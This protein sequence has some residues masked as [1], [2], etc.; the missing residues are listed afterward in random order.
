MNTALKLTLGLVGLGLVAGVAGSLRAQEK[1][2]PRV[3]ALASGHGGYLG[4]YISDVDREVVERL[5]LGEEHGV[6]IQDVAEEGPA[7][8]AGLQEDDVIVSLNGER[9]ESAAQLRRILN[10]T[11][12]G[13]D[14]SL[15]LIR[16]GSQRTISLELGERRSL[17]RVYDF[18]SDRGEHFGE[19]LRER[20][21]R[22]RDNMQDMRIRMRGAPDVHTF[23]AFGG[24]GRLGVSIQSLGDQLGEYFGLGD[25]T[26]VLVTSVAEE[27][28]AAKAGLKAGDVVLAIDG[29]DVE[30]PRDLMR[31]VRRA[32][33]GPVA[34]RVLRD[35]R[36]RTFTVEL[37]DSKLDT[38]RSEEGDVQGFYFGPDLDVDIEGLPDFHLSIPMPD[39]EPVWETLRAVQE[40]PAVSI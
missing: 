30:D 40:V 22:Q 20:L 1:P 19:E 34:L 24:R 39:L 5:G 38:W 7:T 3:R 35:K 12:P 2:E 29:D 23:M 21:E 16:D 18:R 10:E 26:G 11:P 37:P 33:A 8:D 15:D 27:S 32:E 17:A 4:V 6:L 25:R 13:R 28:A 9:I 14:V 36:E 31:L